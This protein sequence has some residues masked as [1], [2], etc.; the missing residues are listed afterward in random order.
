MEQEPTR[1]AFDPGVICQMLK[2]YLKNKK[3]LLV[4]A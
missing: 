4:L 2:G 3:I 1:L